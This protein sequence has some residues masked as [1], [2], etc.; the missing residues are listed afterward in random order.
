M[1]VEPEKRLHLINIV[2][3][4]GATIKKAAQLLGIN[5][6]TSKHIMKQHKA[7]NPHISNLNQLALTQRLL[8]DKKSAAA[9]T[10]L[11]K[12]QQNVTSA[13]VKSNCQPHENQANIED[14]HEDQ[15]GA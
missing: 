1:Q 8:K 2:E 14:W 15:D 10:L 12:I 7:A 5:C 3:V 6:S 11:A 9:D 4:E 13:V